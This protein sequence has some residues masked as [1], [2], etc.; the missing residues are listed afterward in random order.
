MENQQRAQNNIQ[1]NNEQEP[2][3]PVGSDVPSAPKKMRRSSGE[4][5]KETVQSGGLPRPFD[6]LK[7][8]KSAR[9][10]FGEPLPTLPDYSNLPVPPIPTGPKSHRARCLSRLHEGHVAIRRHTGIFSPA[11]EVSG[12][13]NKK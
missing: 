7:K 4:G 8:P 9:R 11:N 10:L 1:L 2:V 13:C 5:I 3:E 12:K 6:Y